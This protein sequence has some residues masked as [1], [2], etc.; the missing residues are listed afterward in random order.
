MAAAPKQAAPE[1]G[2]GAGEGF[3]HSGPDVRPRPRARW[4]RGDFGGYAAAG[5]LLSSPAR[6]GAQPTAISGPTHTTAPLKTHLHGFP[7]AAD[8][9]D[10]VPLQDGDAAFGG[11]GGSHP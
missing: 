5:K 3:R 9:I 11:A 1:A 7:V 10:T 4:Q 8:R 2:L 6:S